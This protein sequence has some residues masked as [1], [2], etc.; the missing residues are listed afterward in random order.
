MLVCT[1][2]R[3]VWPSNCAGTDASCGLAVQVTTHCA[4][5]PRRWPSSAPAGAP[6]QKHS[7]MAASAASQRRRVMPVEWPPAR[8]MDASDEPGLV[9]VL[10]CR[11]SLRL[12]L[13]I[14]R[15]GCECG[16]ARAMDRGNRPA[17]ELPARGHQV[18]PRGLELHASGDPVPRCIA[19]STRTRFNR[20]SEASPSA[21]PRPSSSPPRSSSRRTRATGACRRA[22]RA[23]E[24]HRCS[25]RPRSA[26]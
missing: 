5:S 7:T 13:W 19:C 3:R 20:R 22:A 24:S 11:C 26:S 4:S 15:H 18:K 6:V 21:L 25:A 17:T 8:R 1:I 2:C 14:D 10:V 9:G 16:Q 12:V 23:D